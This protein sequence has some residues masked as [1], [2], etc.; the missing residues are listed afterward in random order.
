[1]YSFITTNN[2]NTITVSMFV[3]GKYVGKCVYT[4]NFIKLL[5]IQKEFRGLNYGSILLKEIEQRIDNNKI[6]LDVEELDE[7]H[8]HLVDWYKIHGYKQIGLERYIYKDDVL[9]RIIPMQLQKVNIF[10]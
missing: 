4:N 6:L 1:M 5:L 8:G 7:K 2:N 3:V 10:S 9:V